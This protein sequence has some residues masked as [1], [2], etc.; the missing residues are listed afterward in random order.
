MKSWPQHMISMCSGLIS[1]F[2]A[3][4]CMQDGKVHL[5]AAP[6]CS[7]PGGSV[8]HW[9]QVELYVKPTCPGMFRMWSRAWTRSSDEFDI[10]FPVQPC[11]GFMER[12]APHQLVG[13]VP[14]AQGKPHASRPP[15]ATK[16]PSRSLLLSGIAPESGSSETVRRSVQ[17]PE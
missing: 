6:A 8:H 1:G 13:R 10:S 12:R 16:L 4:H 9:G 3:D 5:Q 7:G 11:A 15:R 17:V 14:E 2:L